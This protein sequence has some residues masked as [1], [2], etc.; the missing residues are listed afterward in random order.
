MEAILTGKDCFI[1]KPEWRSLN[2]PNLFEKYEIID[3]LF[4]IRS[5]L[6]SLL[7]DV[8]GYAQGTRLDFDDLL[9]RAQ[10]FQRGLSSLH[11]SF[12]DPWST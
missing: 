10:S 8:R 9:A 5:T 3:H 2:N 4:D 7:R 11:R 6:P 12:R 1:S